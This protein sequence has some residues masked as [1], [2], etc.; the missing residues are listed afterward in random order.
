[1]GAEIDRVEIQVEAQATKANNQLDKLVGKLDAL[2]SSLSHLNTGG[3][4]G[5]ANGVQKFAQASAQLSNVKTA[6]F[7]RLAK[8]IEK[9]STINTQQIY[10]A[11]SA[12]SRMSI[13]LNG[14]SGSSAGSA[15]VVALA[16]SISKL[17]GAN[18]QRA[19]TNMP[20][21]ASALNNLFVTLSKAPTVNANIIMMTN[22]LAKLA[23]QGAKVGTA[24]SSLVSSVNS[25]GR[26]ME[27]NTKK[28]KGL[29][30]A[31]GKLYQDYFLVIRGARK[32]WSSVQGSMNY[33]ETLNYF[34]AAFEQLADSAAQSGTQSADAYFES[35]SSRA[36]ELTS[37]MTGFTVN[38]NGILTAT[39]EA[40]LGINPTQLMNY[41]AMFTQ[42]SNSMGVSADTSVKLSQAMTELGG[43]LASVKNMD[44]DKVWKDMASGLV[45]MSRTMDKYG[46]NIRNVNLQ[47]KLF[48]LGID[49][50][51]SELNQSDKA[52]LRGIIM[53][54]RTKYAW[55]DLADTLNQPANQLRMLNSNFNN[56]SRTIGN[57]F[58][59]VVAKTLPY[60]NGLVIA[61]QRLF[62]W[63][64]TLLGIDL[65]GITS[66][67]GSEDYDYGELLDDTEA[68]TD[69]LN[70]ASKAADKLKRGI[71]GFDELNVISS[72]DDSSSGGISGGGIQAGLL[73]A[74]FDAALADYQKVWDE[75]FANVE[76]RANQFADKIEK[77]LQPV[78]D[79]IEDF[80]VGDF[81]KAGQDTSKLVR[82]IL[83]FFSD[84][85]DR[86]DW[87]GIGKNIGDFLAGLNW[88]KIII[89][90]LKLKFNIWKAIAETW[91]G[92][93]SAAPIETSILTAIG[94]LKFTKLGTILG[95][96]LK[97]QISTALTNAGLAVVNAIAGQ[98]GF[99][100]FLKADIGALIGT[101]STAIIGATIGTAIVGSIVAWLGGN[102]AG[103]KIGAALC[104]DEADIYE[105]FRWLGEGG[106]LDEFKKSIKDGVWKDALKQWG[107]DIEN[108]LIAIGNDEATWVEDHIS[109]PIKDGWNKLSD[110]YDGTMVGQL[111]SSFTDGTWKDALSL[112][113]DEDISPWFTKEQWLNFGVNIHSG[114]STKWTEFTTW[115][116][117]TGV[118]KW[119]EDVRKKFSSSQWNNFGENIKNGLSEKWNSFKEWWDDTGFKQWWDG[120]TEK[121]SLDNWN[122]SGIKDGLSQAWT[123]AIEAI[124]QIWNNFALWLNEK[125]NFSWDGLTIAGKEI[126]PS[127]NLNLGKIPTF[128]IGGFPEDGLFMANHNE[129]VGQFANGKTAVANNEQIT[130]G[131]EEAAYRGM[132]RALSESSGSTNVDI[133]VDGDPHGMFKV[134]KEEWNGES[135]RLQKNPVRIMTT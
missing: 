124:K 86:V 74:A 6:D 87:A 4:S 33:V 58:L 93:F 105:N 37:K 117:S 15:Q 111:T 36:K 123:N 28:V 39:G 2:S 55:G 135:R 63:I 54:E 16:N 108:G 52:L 92:S 8:N 128:S 67:I 84:A 109:K 75:A 98:G 45:G 96:A 78:K 5:L 51:I 59:P 23:S 80:A 57:L 43:D 82:G 41:Q 127:G 114:L 61:L 88:T 70:D 25:V 3:L 83:D 10:S 90:A 19:I 69:G 46:V 48:E 14:L 76:N 125:L 132:V 121:F 134:W 97:P 119:W 100:A 89:S 30:S 126:V 77:Y 31:I 73:D 102:W 17:G 113:W 94:L 104:P 66:T 85:I 130:A 120:V 44:F 12:I 72:K 95:N 24:G 64:G 20:A 62:S 115:W 118:S 68:L 129:L 47:E 53:L 60:I 26:S 11:S 29:S 9:L 50:Q 112:W 21:L 1:M 40:S 49:A 27:S 122:F 56:L 110:W 131:I 13:A 65:S 35:F 103:K 101:G 42:M 71:R 91:F 79:I 34:D 7:T 38:D 18:V 106:F 99:L 116:E 22:S 32:L 133:H 107:T 81:F